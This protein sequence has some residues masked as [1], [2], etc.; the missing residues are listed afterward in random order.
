MRQRGS[1]PPARIG[2]VGS[3]CR[4]G[5]GRRGTVRRL[6][7]SQPDDDEQTPGGLAGAWLAAGL[8]VTA[9]TA[10]TPDTDRGH[11]VPGVATRAGW[12]VVEYRGTRVDVPGTWLRLDRSG[13]EFEHE[14]WAP[15]GS[16]RC[17]EGVGV[18]FYAAATFDPAR[19]PGARPDD[20]P[21]ARGGAWAGY[22]IAG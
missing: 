6:D 17:A 14:R 1:R 10:C 15:Q 22:E 12:Q 16:H 20:G 21:G 7:P 13:C 5:S 11:L 18:S 4:H 3:R 9:A 8:L 2:R 19:G